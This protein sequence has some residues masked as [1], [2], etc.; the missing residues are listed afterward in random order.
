MVDPA[1]LPGFLIAVLLI[2][3]APGTDMAFIIAMSVGRGSRAGVQS[4]VGMAIG[5]AIWTAAAALGLGALLHA[6]PA[7]FASLR[8]LGAVYLL[9]LGVT[10]LRSARADAN[11]ETPSPPAPTY[12][13][14]R[15]ML[16][17]LTNP[18]ILVF[19]VA[20]LPQFVSTSSNGEGM[21]LLILGGLFLL[22]GFSVDCLVALSAGKL[23]SMLRPGGRAATTL[24]VAA[25][26][27]FC[28]LAVALAA[29]AAF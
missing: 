18:K 26:A 25:G 24:N 8:V 2:C 4:A 15:G 28:V 21:Q 9:W 29:E 27:T 19:F 20:F 13:V 12:L 7:V 22:V 11:T 1:V 17:N 3:L 10:A 23:R 16:T 5:M 14:G 6:E